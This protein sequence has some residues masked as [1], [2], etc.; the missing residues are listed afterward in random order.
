MW[1]LEE[2]EKE[3]SLGEMGLA[4]SSREVVVV[5]GAVPGSRG[6]S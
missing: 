1:A 3:K 6:F 5:A 2:E 4:E